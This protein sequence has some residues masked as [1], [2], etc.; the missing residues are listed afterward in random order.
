MEGI[1]VVTLVILLVG[2]VIVDVL[3]MRRG[4]DS[5]FSHGCKYDHPRSW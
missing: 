1:Q 4:F 3:A 5:R 2:L